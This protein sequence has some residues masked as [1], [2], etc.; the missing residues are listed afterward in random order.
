M[1]ENDMNKNEV[2]MMGQK[3]KQFV[4][5]VTAM[6]DDFAQW[7]TDV[8]KQAE[9]VDYGP[10]RGT[11]IIK[12]YGFAIWENIRNELDRK[13]KETGHSNVSFPLFIPESLL[14]KEK[15]HIEGFAPEV[16]WVTHGGE[17]ELNERVCVRP[18]S[19][20]LFGEYYAKT[21]NSYRDLPKLYNQWSNVVRWEKTT[22]PFL[23]SLEFLWQ[24]GH[25]CHA[26][27]EEAEQETRQMLD[28]YADVCENYL[29]IPVVKG[30]KTEKEKFAGA[31]YTLT[32][33]SLMHDGKALQSGTSHYFGTGFAEA[34]DI[35]FLDE[36]GEQKPV[37]QT[38]WG[39]STRI[40]GGLIMVHGD[41]RGLVIPPR[42][43][44]TQAMIVPVAQH[45]EGVLDQAYALRDQLQDLVRVDIDASDKMPGWKFN[46]Y[47]MKGIPVRI[48]I[49]PKDIEKNQ[50]VLVRRD[51]GEKT[52]V[53]RNE[54]DNRLPAL[55]GEIQQNLYDKALAHREE[56]TTTAVDM[57][58]F[59]RNLDETPGFIKAM[60]CGDTAC[61]EKI[62]EATSATS[63]CIPFEQEKVA[64]TCVCCGKKA[65]EMVYWA[66]AY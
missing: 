52:F 63:R 27:G 15:D 53:P 34:F 5:K 51:T 25:T 54:L 43:A 13:F 32:I 29:A 2:M 62:K 39:M 3:D 50:V 16:A 12:P 9:L 17:E 35:R 49:G 47:E 20:V 56:T 45:K 6:E 4:E 40:I 60:W 61:E 21:I 44:P 10:V 33:E 7:Y 22:R 64:D 48:E 1:S 59:A 58:E 41:N 46:E 66:K 23:R 55:L 8:V 38:S 36:N 30:R 37:H 65:K 26:T 11:M 42:I 24:E 28:I 18:T 57:D 19:E 31:E 14:Q